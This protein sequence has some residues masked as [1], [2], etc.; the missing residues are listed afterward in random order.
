[1][2]CTLEI[3]AMQ[4]DGEMFVIFICN[5]SEGKSKEKQSK[6]SQQMNGQKTSMNVFPYFEM[7]A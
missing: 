3:K 1:M 6:L 2:L 5:V 7:I 4:A